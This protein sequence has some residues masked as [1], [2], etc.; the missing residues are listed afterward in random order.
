[1]LASLASFV[2]L[3]GRYGLGMEDVS[4]ATALV[5]LAGAVIGALVA[6]AF[7]LVA[8]K[9]NS[10][11]LRA[12][13]RHE[14]ASRY[15]ADL[16][17]ARD[18]YWRATDGLVITVDEMVHEHGGTLE[19]RR[20]VELNKDR[21]LYFEKMQA[22]AWDSSKLHAQLRIEF[23]AMAHAA[24]ALIDASDVRGGG[25]EALL[26]KKQA[27]LDAQAEFEKQAREVLESIDRVRWLPFR[28]RPNYRQAPTG[29]A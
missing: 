17:T 26:Q 14:R 21:L 28:R 20:A 3:A 18:V 8:A 24:A 19:A 15:I 27:Y 6:G 16:W 11:A 12:K 2:V 7:Q 22:A 10:H 13:D 25:L 29:P 23:P 4:T 5:G 9:L 1:M